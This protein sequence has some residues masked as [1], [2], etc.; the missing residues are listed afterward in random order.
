MSLKDHV[1]KDIEEKIMW[2]TYIM[3]YNVCACV[4]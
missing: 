2:K 4:L 3:Y 1:N